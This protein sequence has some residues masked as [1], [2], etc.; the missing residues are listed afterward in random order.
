MSKILVL[1]STTDGHTQR[2]C[3]RLQQVMAQPGHAV[4]VAP[5]AQADGLDLECFDKIVIGASI[6][7]GK[8]QPMV[9]QFIDRRQA[10]LERK[11]NAFFSVNIV[12]RKPEKNRPDTN[13]YL[14]KYLRTL[15]WQPQ[16]LGVFAGKLDYP[17]YGVMDRFMIRL[18]MFMTNG[19]TDPKAV[20]EFTNW[21][22]VEAFG[23]Q[24]C[25]LD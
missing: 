6:R 22:Q 21:Q 18:I 16:L 5:L 8:H 13:P 24:V 23:L 14:I 10:L 1:Y 17:R 7:Y 20:V 15:S 25:A 11:S 19:P 9:K 2:I 3:E 12:A 4:T